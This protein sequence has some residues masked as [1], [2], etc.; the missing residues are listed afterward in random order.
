MYTFNDIYKS[1][2]S[3]EVQYHGML[4]I[5]SKVTIYNDRVINMPCSISHNSIYSKQPIPRIIQH[6]EYHLTLKYRSNGNITYTYKRI[7]K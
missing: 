6:L 2:W 7:H 4:D 1:T 5:F 3:F